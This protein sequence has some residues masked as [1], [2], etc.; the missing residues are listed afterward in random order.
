MAAAL[1]EGVGVDFV[2]KGSVP[3]RFFDLFARDPGR[4]SCQ[5]GLTTLDDGLRRQ[6]EPGAATVDDPDVTLFET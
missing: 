6:L 1:G 3:E 2:T 4:V 5:V